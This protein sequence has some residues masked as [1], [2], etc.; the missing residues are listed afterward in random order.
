MENGRIGLIILYLKYKF[1]GRLSLT[2]IPTEL[3]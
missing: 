1:S 2:V 3:I